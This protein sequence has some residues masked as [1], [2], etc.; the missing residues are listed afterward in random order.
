MGREIARLTTDEMIYTMLNPRTNQVY[1]FA[2]LETLIITVTTALK[3]QSFNLGFMQEGN[4]PEGFI[5]LPK[6]IAS[7]RDQLKEWQDAWD[8]MLSGDPRF[9]RKLK[10]LPEG[11]EYKPA[12]N[13]ADMSF[14][15][16]EKWLLQNTCAVFGV[17]P[18]A[19]GFNFETNKASAQTTWEAGKER[20]LFPT[21]LFVKELMDKI[22]QEDMG[23][24][25]LEFSWTNMDPTNKKEEADTVKILVN[26]GLLSIDEWRIGEGLKPT[27]A[28]DPF[29][30]TPVG[31]IFVKDLAAQSDAGQ[32]PIL[33]YKP[34]AEA[35]VASQNAGNAL[36]VPNVPPQ[37]AT[38]AQNKP[39]NGN[40]PPP[41]SKKSEEH[42]DELRRWKKASIKDFKLK[43]SPRDFKTDILD[44]R[45]QGL[46]RKGLADATIREEVEKVFEPF[47]N[48]QSKTISSLM[49]VYDE[50]NNIQSQNPQS[51][52]A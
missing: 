37:A 38:G 35:A 5:T 32:M 8:S 36:A 30:M 21:A 33:P 16:F 24:E 28:R 9:Q 50:L 29:I 48:L 22:I 6:E 20:G 34:P 51:S 39:T 40:T 15:R 23:Y 46:I 11:M 42:F 45:T 26:S 41:K 7:S 4:I 43:R 2:A 1:G 12:I 52:A 49:D 47:L 25:D 14:E 27:G 31:P 17:P 18:T 3:V 10:F 44:V 19:I 13:P